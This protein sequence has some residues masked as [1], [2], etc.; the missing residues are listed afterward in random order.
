MVPHGDPQGA[1]PH[2]TH[3]T[4]QKMGSGCWRRK[5]GSSQ[6]LPRALQTGLV[7]RGCLLS[8]CSPSLLAIPPTT[9]PIC[10]NSLVLCGTC[11][12]V[13]IFPMED[14][15]KRQETSC[16]L[17]GSLQGGPKQDPRAPKPDH[18]PLLIWTH[19]MLIL[20]LSCNSHSKILNLLC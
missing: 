6:R 3:P 11:G 12:K 16:Y 8:S 2:R 14:Q 15:K 19:L 13:R 10:S 20:H 9:S 18:P 5:P 17:R 7:V 4:T 1:F